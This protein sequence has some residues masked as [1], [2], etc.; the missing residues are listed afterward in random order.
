MAKRGTANF[1]RVPVGLV[2]VGVGFF[3][4]LRFI[5]ECDVCEAA[6][7]ML[8]GVVPG[9]CSITVV[10]GAQASNLP[11]SASGAQRVVIGTVQQNCTGNRSY[12]LSVTSTNC[13]TAPTGGKVV[14]P[15]WGDYLRYSVEFVNPTTGGSQADVIGLMA[16]SCTNQIARVVDHAHISGET[17]TVYTNFTGD[18]TL[19][20][21]TYEDVV[22]ISL[23]MQ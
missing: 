13:P 10:P 11:I 4:A 14:V 17:S 16:S 15:V 1:W 18:T 23:T 22:L 8:I 21:G 20:A 6:T 2:V 12:T 7:I 3:G 19:T 9:K 5:G